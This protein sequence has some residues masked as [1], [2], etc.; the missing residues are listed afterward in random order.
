M[1]L[2]ILIIFILLFFSYKLQSD[3]FKNKRIEAIELLKEGKSQNDK[4]LILQGL[5]KM[6]YLSKIGDVE[7]MFALGRIYLAGTTVDKNFGSSYEWFLK[8]GKS[9]HKKSLLVLDKFF[10]NKKSSK[11]FSPSEYSNIINN[12]LRSSST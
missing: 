7:S 11:F 10:L 3:Q 4:R 2:N 8:A 6:K 1:K 5:R 9:Y 12:T